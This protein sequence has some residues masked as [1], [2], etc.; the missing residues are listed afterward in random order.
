MLLDLTNTKEQTFDVLPAGNYLVTC[1]AAQVKPTSNSQGTYIE[2]EMK[3][4]EGDAE[5][6]KIWHRFN[7]QNNNDKAQ[8]IGLSQLKTFMVKAGHPDPNKLTEVNELC[9]LSAVARVIVRQDP[10]YNPSNEIKSFVSKTDSE[11]KG[12]TDFAPPAESF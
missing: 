2:C 12:T 9:G 5:G 7:I 4:A 3:V 6:R 8:E 1:V 10:G 11:E